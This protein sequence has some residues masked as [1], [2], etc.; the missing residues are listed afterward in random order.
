MGLELA[1]TDAM[2]STVGVKLRSLRRRSHLTM[3]ALAR[4][5][6]VAVSHICNIEAG[7]SSASLATLRKLLVALG[8]DMGPFFADDLPVPPGG[9]FRRAYMRTAA[10]A[11]RCYTFILPDRPDVQLIMMD[12]ELVAGEEPAYETLSGDLAGYVLQGELS[13]DVRGEPAQI[14][15]P[16]DAFYVRAGRPVRGRCV[17]GRMVRL[18]TVE[19]T[20]RKSSP[21]GR[22]AR[23]AIRPNKHLLKRGNLA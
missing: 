6:G 10:D 4:R 9:V 2:W 22:S 20:K 16:G 17:R 15:Q 13:L 3:R 5:A 12:E 19:T 11:G 21:G 18:V 1:V 14:L 7:R 8:T 23:R